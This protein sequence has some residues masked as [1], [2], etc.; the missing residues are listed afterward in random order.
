LCGSSTADGNVLCD[1]YNTMPTTGQTKLTNWCAKN[2]DGSGSFVTDPC[3]NSPGWL[4]VTCQTVG[5]MVRITG[6]KLENLA[7]GGSLPPSIG[8]LN[9]LTFLQLTGDSISGSLPSTIGLLTALQTLSLYSNWIAGSLPS[10][11]G[12]LTALQTLTLSDNMLSGQLPSSI[13]SLTSLKSLQLGAYQ[14]MYISYNQ[15]EWI[16]Y[17]TASPIGGNRLQGQIPSSI[18][19]MKSLTYLDL[20]FNKFNGSDLFA[21][22]GL[23][24]KPTILLGNYFKGFIIH[25]FIVLIF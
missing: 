9:A 7:L 22:C 1:F 24:S 4:G 8:G 25:L 20:T 23:T 17:A 13:G 18:G 5:G 19:G 3:S 12:L 15:G 14:A 21:L 6:L 16:D 11:I 2:V 10:T